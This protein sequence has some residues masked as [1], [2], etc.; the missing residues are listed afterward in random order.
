MMMMM[1]VDQV[2][3]SHKVLVFGSG[4]REHAIACKLLE[5]VS[6]NHVFVCPGNAGMTK[7]HNISVT[8]KQ[9]YSLLY[10]F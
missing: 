6:V 5:S 3:G 2:M 4:G 10:N 1:M 7:L 8:C 9:T